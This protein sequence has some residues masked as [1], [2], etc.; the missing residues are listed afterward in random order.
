MTLEPHHYPRWWLGNGVWCLSFDGQGCWCFGAQQEGQASWAEWSTVPTL[1][2]VT[3][4]T[5][6]LAEVVVWMARMYRSLVA[7]DADTFRRGTDRPRHS[8]KDIKDTEALYKL[9]EWKVEAVTA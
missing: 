4:P 3:D 2:G 8:L 9:P 7:M 1:E 6:A 5:Q